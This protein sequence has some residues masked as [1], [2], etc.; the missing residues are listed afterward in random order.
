M[1]KVKIKNSKIIKNEILEIIKA[2]TNIKNID[3]QEGR[4]KL[5]IDLDTEIT[6]E[7]QREGEARDIARKIQEE[8]KRLGTKID[9]KVDVE[10]PEWPKEFEEYIKKRGFVAHLTKGTEFKLKLNG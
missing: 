6:Q 4:G 7:L 3:I 9:E 1:G 10:L 2:E 5:Q 8:R